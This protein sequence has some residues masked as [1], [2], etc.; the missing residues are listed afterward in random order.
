MHLDVFAVQIRTSMH[1]YRGIVF[2]VYSNSRS[3]YGKQWHT[4]FVHV[5]ADHARVITGYHHE[6]EFEGSASNSSCR[7]GMELRARGI[8]SNNRSR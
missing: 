6:I 4:F 7:Q 5:A 3:V 1:I 2:A 8:E